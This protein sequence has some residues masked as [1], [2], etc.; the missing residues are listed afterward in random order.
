M[1]PTP[2]ADAPSATATPT[3]PPLT[4]EAALPAPHKLAMLCRGHHGL[5]TTRGWR[6]HHLWP[7]VILWTIPTGHWCI[8]AP[9]DRE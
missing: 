4:A 9:T 6:I 3:T 1:H 2:A 8:T 5:K 7:G